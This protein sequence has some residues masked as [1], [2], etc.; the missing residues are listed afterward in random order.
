MYKFIKFLE[1]VKKF[2]RIK[3]KIFY[4]KLKYGKNLK[5]GKQLIFEKGFHINMSKDGILEIGDY[6]YFNNYCSINC[7]KKITIGD[8]NLFGE[9]IKIYDHSHVFNTINH[10]IK[11]NYSEKIIEV[12]NN[13]WICSNVIILEKTKIGSGNVIGA[14]VVLNKTIDN[15]Y[16][17]KNR[18]DL[19]EIKIERR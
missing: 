15:D 17:V 18:N 1:N 10:N 5:I 2:L 4:Y 16:I 11:K 9:N 7:H 19:Q 8:N 13:N 3:I 6:N 14:G 12:G